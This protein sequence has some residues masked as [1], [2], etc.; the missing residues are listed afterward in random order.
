V[1]QHDPLNTMVGELLTELA[2]LDMEL[3]E[4]LH[5][6][7]D[8]WSDPDDPDLLMAPTDFA[9]KHDQVFMVAEDDFIQRGMDAREQAKINTVPAASRAQERRN[10]RMMKGTANPCHPDAMNDPANW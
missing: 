7:D 6:Q 2:D 9:T 1:L 10:E 3:R 4:A 5:R 8:E